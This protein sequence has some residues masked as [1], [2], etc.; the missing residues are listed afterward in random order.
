MKKQKYIL[1]FSLLVVFLSSCTARSPQIINVHEHIQSE[2]NVEKL[3]EANDKVG[4]EKTVL[5]G[6]PIETLLF[7]GSEGFSRYDENN[8]VL[9]DI[10]KKYPDKFL[11]FCTIYWYD[12]DKLSKL[13]KCVQD[14]A[15][16]LKLYNGHGFYYEMPLDDLR[17]QEIYDYLEKANLPVLFHVN[18]GKYLNEFRN[19][20]EQHPKMKVICPHFCLLSGNLNTLKNLMNDNPNLYVDVSFG[21]ADYMKEGFERFNVDIEKYRSFFIEYQDRLL[22]GTDAVVTDASFKNADWF[23]QMF[24]FYKQWLEQENFTFNVEKPVSINIEAKGLH[25]PADILEKIY[26]DNAEEF[27][28]L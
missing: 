25:L 6:S 7:D 28:G 22:F 4:I 14:G 20:L 3:L 15:K 1:I 27:L 9:L 16:G 12:Q 24:S 2:E 10:A 26:H 18:G 13:K 5:L 19:V 23:A 8:Q 11:A 17:M 21:Y